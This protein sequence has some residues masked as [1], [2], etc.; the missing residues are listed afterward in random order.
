[1]FEDKNDEIFLSRWMNGELTEQ[2]LKDF[3][4]HPDYKEY[5]KILAGTEALDIR[6]YDENAA[7]ARIKSAKNKSANTSSKVIKFIPYI[8]IAASIALI[9]GLFLFTGNSKFETGYGE[10]LAVTLPD[11]SE[12]ILN[13]KS[14]AN[15]N[16]KSWK[17]NRVVSLDGEAYFKVKKGSKFTVATQQGEVTVLG[18]QFNVQSS[19]NL[20][21]AICYE[22]KVSV[23]SGEHGTILTAGKAFR[24]IAN[25][26]P[27]NWKFTT[28]KPSWIANQSSFKSTPIVYVLKKLQDQY[29]V[30]INTSGID[31]DITYTGTFPNTNLKLALKTVFSTL[32]INYSLS[33]DGKTIMLEK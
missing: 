15:Y 12:M 11:G 31:S 7:L 16:T 5:A 2:E 32:G 19:K 14:K 17:D 9:A 28:T 24:T 13:A 6:T 26:T 10:Q 4:E 21:E 8:A 33:K 23:T 25:K 1:M 18:T 29:N 20:F 22:G 3:Q 30:N 27:E